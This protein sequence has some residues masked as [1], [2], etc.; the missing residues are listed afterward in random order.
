MSKPEPLIDGKEVAKFLHVSYPSVLRWLSEGHGPPH[1][2][3][4][5]PTL[6]SGNIRKR[7]GKPRRPRHLVRFKLSEVEE[8]LKARKGE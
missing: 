1:Y 5:K 8:W 6:S 2:V 4:N 3:L 7:N